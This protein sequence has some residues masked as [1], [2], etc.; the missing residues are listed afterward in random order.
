MQHTR[1][2]N[3]RNGKQQ[4]QQA[5]HECRRQVGRSRCCPSPVASSSS[6]ALMV[7]MAGAIFILSVMDRIQTTHSFESPATK[8]SSSSF[9]RD[10]SYSSPC[11]IPVSP[12]V[13]SSRL[14]PSARKKI[15][16]L[17]S[18]F[19]TFSKTRSN[20][21]QRMFC[22]V[23]SVSRNNLS[24]LRRHCCH[25]G[26]HFRLHAVAASSGSSANAS[27]INQRKEE[28]GMFIPAKQDTGNYGVAIIQNNVPEKE[29]YQY[30]SFNDHTKHEE[31]SFNFNQLND[32][33][34]DDGG[35]Y[36]HNNSR[37]HRGDG[38]PWVLQRH[39]DFFLLRLP[40][41]FYSTSWRTLLNTLVYLLIPMT[42]VVS[43]LQQQHP[44]SKRQSYSIYVLSC[45]ND[46]Y[47]VGSTTNL[48]RRIHQ[49]LSPGGG[50]SW[51]RTHKPLRLVQVYKNI[52]REYYLGKE[53]QVTAEL[54]LSHGVNNVR[55]AM[56]SETREYSV[57]D[58]PAL[59][60]FLGHYNDVSYRQLGRWLY[61]ELWLLQNKK[62]ENEERME[63]AQ[64]Q[65]QK[66]QVQFR[67]ETTMTSTTTPP[68]FQSKYKRYDKCFCC[69]KL[70]HWA[71]EC[72]N[73]Q[74]KVRVAS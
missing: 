36:R 74:V 50:S 43:L 52:P 2:N 45:Q 9:K 38:R 15:T 6:P 39:H 33:E 25:F 54:M 42:F 3:S 72:P 35:D 21:L 24:R 49:H 17:S 64:V 73:R 47:Y 13:P 65:M 14:S 32:D 60:G 62:E 34:V 68:R 12:A 41:F 53:A 4:N 70:G 71:R 27:G 31:D 40:S 69:G 10:V 66:M 57:E 11:G 16:Q 23:A 8:R 19:P 26:S 46:K 59:K 63:A 56:F 30:P 51:T 29:K 55:G 1:S 48:T 67:T 22:D 5:M 7:F 58:I 44:S 61:R 37:Q 18:T 28:D 20:V